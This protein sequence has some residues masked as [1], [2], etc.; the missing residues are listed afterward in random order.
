MS[1]VF[2]KTCMA[3]TS[4]HSPLFNLYTSYSTHSIDLFFWHWLTFILLFR[5]V[6]LVSCHLNYIV[7]ST[8][9]ISF[10]LS[11]QF[12][13]IWTSLQITN[14]PTNQIEAFPYLSIYLNCLLVWLSFPLP[15]RVCNSHLHCS[16][17]YSL[18]LD[19]TLTLA[20]VGCCLLHLFTLCPRPFRLLHWLLSLS[21]PYTLLFPRLIYSQHSLDI[22]LCFSIWNMLKWRIFQKT[23]LSEVQNHV[24]SC[25]FVDLKPKQNSFSPQSIFL[26]SPSSS[27]KLA[28]LIPFSLPFTFMAQ[29]VLLLSL[30]NIQVFPFHFLQ[31]HSCSPCLFP[32]W[33]EPFI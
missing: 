32:K 15:T 4:H 31:C 16:A 19:G 18:G 12:I 30:E 23:H 7:S 5:A 8:S 2:L 26:Y 25:F 24:S 13:N 11:A 1:H 17:L 14:L 10:D 33:P 6:W 22:F 21:S 3:V 9:S 28:Q 29:L 20:S 27:G